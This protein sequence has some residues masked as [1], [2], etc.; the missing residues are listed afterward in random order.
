MRY[1]QIVSWGED[2]TVQFVDGL[3]AYAD[4]DVC[5]VGI[6]DLAGPLGLIEKVRVVDGWGETPRY[7][8]RRV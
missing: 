2:N 8:V 5:V 4:F 6:G 3:G 7:R 1:V